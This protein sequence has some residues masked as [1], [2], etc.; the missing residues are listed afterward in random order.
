MPQALSPCPDL[1]IILCTCPDSAI[2]EKIANAL[3]HDRIAA[4][5]TQLPGAISTYFWEGHVETS[6]EVQL[7]IKTYTTHLNAATACIQHIHPH[8][9]PEILVFSA[10]SGISSYVSW[11]YTTLHAHLQ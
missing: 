6:N 5:V 10:Q 2:A 11:V 1:K 7:L 3:V 8:S 9:V 4:C